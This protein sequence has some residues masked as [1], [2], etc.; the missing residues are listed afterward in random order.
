LELLYWRAY[1]RITGSV[2]VGRRLEFGLGMIA[3][4]NFNLHRGSNTEP[5][6]PADYMFEYQDEN[7]EEDPMEVARRIEAAFCKHF[8]S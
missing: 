8:G 2:D 5:R 3:A 1:D 7:E 4:S 6:A